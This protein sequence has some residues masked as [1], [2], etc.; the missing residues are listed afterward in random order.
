LHP[1]VDANAKLRLK[2]HLR[3][4]TAFCELEMYVEG[5]LDYEAAIKIDPQNKS[6][7]ADAQNIRNI[8]QSG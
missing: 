8:I 6:L 2:S 7:L 1:V 4:A 3:R 5:L